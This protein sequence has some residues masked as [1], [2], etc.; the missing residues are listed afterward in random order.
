MPMKRRVTK[1]RLTFPP[2]IERLIAGDEI[3]RTQANF[4]EFAAL[5]YLHIPR[6][7]PIDAIERAVAYLDQWRAEF[8]WELCLQQGIADTIQRLI[9]GRPIQRSEQNRR[10]LVQAMF[11]WYGSGLTAEHLERANALVKNWSQWR[12]ADGALVDPPPGAE[13]LS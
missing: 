9:D 7:V 3:E 10:L 4:D 13:V 12:K 2:L 8:R 11:D 1:T 5:K 6:G